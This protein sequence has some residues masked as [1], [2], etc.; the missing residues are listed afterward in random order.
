MTEQ[1]KKAF[2]AEAQRM[3]KHS[4]E[5]VTGAEMVEGL[6]TAALLQI[7]VELADIAA[8]QLAICRSSAS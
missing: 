1:T 5:E 6:Q 2:E 7:A 8:S 4:R 3:L